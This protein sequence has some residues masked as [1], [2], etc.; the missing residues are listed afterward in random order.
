MFF[1]QNYKLYPRIRDCREDSDITQANIAKKL[2]M[3]T[4]QYRRYELAESPISLEL[5]EIL[6]DLYNISLDYLAGRT[7][8]KKG[9]NKS[10]LPHSEV[11]L[12]KKFRTLSERQRGVIIGRIEAFTEE[13]AEIAEKEER[14]KGAV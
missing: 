10:D 14:L 6:A 3:G 11:D 12:L 13:N 8:D 2:S 4:T 9:F 5:A 1:I 7:N